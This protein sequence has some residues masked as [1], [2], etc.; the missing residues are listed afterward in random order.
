MVTKGNSG[1]ER[2][3]LEF[4]INRYTLFY[5]CKINN[6]DILYS[7]GNYIQ[8]LVMTYNGKKPEKVDLDIH[9]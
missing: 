6:M 1:G 5:I 8:Y 7:T 4:G 9:V 2:D 3:K